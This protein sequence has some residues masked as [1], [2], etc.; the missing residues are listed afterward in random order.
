MINKKNLH[1][2]IS[3]DQLEKISYED[4]RAINDDF[5]PTELFDENDDEDQ[6]YLAEYNLGPEKVH[7]EEQTKN[8]IRSIE[9]YGK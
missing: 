5:K 6:M 8:L 9:D 7:K 1:N 4:L 2:R 3:W